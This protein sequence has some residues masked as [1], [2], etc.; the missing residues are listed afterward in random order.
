MRGHKI[1]PW[2]TNFARFANAPVTFDPTRDPNWLGNEV[3][4]QLYGTHF[5]KPGTPRMPLRAV[6]LG[7]GLGLTPNAPENHAPAVLKEDTWTG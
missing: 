4:E 7:D 3:Q 5:L 1:P 6:P 2:F